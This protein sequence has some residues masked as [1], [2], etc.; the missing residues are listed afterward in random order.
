M[1]MAFMSCGSNLGGPKTSL[2]WQLARLV[3]NGD[4]PSDELH[5]LK[6]LISQHTVSSVD[7]VVVIDSILFKMPVQFV[8]LKSY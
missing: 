2:F 6:S 8:R 4:R 7:S 3:K 1:N 5:R